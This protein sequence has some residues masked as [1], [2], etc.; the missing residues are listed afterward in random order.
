MARRH[1][2]RSPATTCSAI[3]NHSRL[4]HGID[5]RSVAARCFRDIC[6]TYEL[7]ADGDVTEVERGLIR[8]AANF[9]GSWT[10]FRGD[11]VTKSKPIPGPH[12]VYA[13]LTA[14]P[15]AVANKGADFSNWG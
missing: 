2:E 8:Q 14:S 15:N 10:E 13:F 12:L 4:L 3:S 11:R 7:E 6:R 9:A 1:I 5:G